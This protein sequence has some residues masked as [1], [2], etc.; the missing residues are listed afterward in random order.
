M[1][2][3][4][5]YREWLGIQSESKPTYYQLIGISPSEADSHEIRQQALSQLKKL[6]QIN[7]PARQKLKQE[8][9]VRIKRAVKCLMDQEQR[10]RY[11]R[12]LLVAPQEATQ[13]SA[14]LVTPTFEISDKHPSE[15]A[16]IAIDAVAAQPMS[17]SR[18]Y[19]TIQKRTNTL[20]LCMALGIVSLAGLGFLIGTQTQ[21]GRSMLGL[22]AQITAPTANNQPDF[23]ADA[24]PLP[25]ESEDFA[26]EPYE[27]LDMETTNEQ[28]KA[29]TEAEPQS[30]DEPTPSIEELRALGEA[31]IRA[32][33][34]LVDRDPQ[35][36]KQILADVK[37]LPQRS[38]D[39]AKYDRLVMLADY[40]DSYW[41]AT[42]DALDKLGGGSEIIASGKRMIVVEIN[43]EQLVVRVDG[44]NT[45]LQSDNLPLALEISLAD[46]W[47]DD[48]AASSKV[49]RGAMM[50]V[51]PEFGAD[52]A[53]ELWR[54]A[55]NA[56]ADINDIE[57]VLDDNYDLAGSMQ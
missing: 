25:M 42:E 20:L 38:A 41:Q 33:D 43:Q 18:R 45:T 40:V 36:A 34:A 6:A 23:D 32:H 7:D 9:T 4:N 12:K 2:E 24:K 8:L 53:R 47:F 16:A 1:S 49:F 13:Q 46:S 57:K 39:R 28:D 55:R 22:S 3:F 52:E 19:K 15:L 51:T 21:S 54:Q 11:D 27:Q 35:F 10:I 48:T 5:P 56:G 31:L 37:L 30:I 50:A 17:V 14:E 44:R 26:D 29:S